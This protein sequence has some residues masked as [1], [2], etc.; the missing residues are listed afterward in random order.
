MRRELLNRIIIKLGKH[1]HGKDDD[2]K[3][4]NNAYNSLSLIDQL[5]DQVC[6]SDKGAS[7]K[8]D[9]NR[10]QGQSSANKNVTEKVFIQMGMKI[11]ILH[12]C[13][14]QIE[15]GEI[16]SLTDKEMKALIAKKTKIVKAKNMS[17]YFGI[18]YE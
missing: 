1:S 4:E 13:Y 18:I 7:G 8:H 12:E 11:M 5:L 15:V 16:N 6:T 10:C 9:H 17:K 2:H 14:A 3:D